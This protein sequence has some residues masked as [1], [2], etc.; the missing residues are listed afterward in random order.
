MKIDKEALLKIYDEI[1]LIYMSKNVTNIFKVTLIELLQQRL[2]L[3]NEMISE[4]V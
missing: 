4:Y 1:L 2:Q 3:K